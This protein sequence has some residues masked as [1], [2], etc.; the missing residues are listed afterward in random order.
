[1]TLNTM[2][3][4]TKDRAEKIIDEIF[5]LIGEQYLYERINSPIE[6][7]A[8]DFEFDKK[9]PV[10]HQNFVRFIQD[11]IRHIYSKGLGTGQVMSDF[12][13]RSKA[14]SILE[15]GYQNVN[16]RGY[17]A[18]FLDSINPDLNGFDLV[19]TRM[20]E[21]IIIMERS[22]HIRWVYATRISALS[23]ATRLLIAE[24]LLERW[25]PFLPSSITG[26]SLVQIADHLPELINILH[27]TDEAAR[28][29]MG[30]IDYYE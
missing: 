2:N 23:W 26:C 21:I 4:K 1:M 27:A 20:T 25:E 28:N 16:D 22:K 5:E 18:A 6:E 15:E 8:L 12:Q 7:A 3:F 19:L 30:H 17:F 11:S 9:V 13:A 24:I 10:T 14:V 29:I